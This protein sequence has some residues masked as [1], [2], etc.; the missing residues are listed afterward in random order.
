[1][2][3]AKKGGFAPLRKAPGWLGSN[4]TDWLSATYMREWSMKRTSSMCTS[5]WLTILLID[6]CQWVVWI[7][8]ADHSLLSVSCGVNGCLREWVRACMWP[9]PCSLWSLWWMWICSFTWVGS[10][11]EVPY[12]LNEMVEGYRGTWV[13]PVRGRGSFPSPHPLR[14]VDSSSGFTV[15][16]VGGSGQVEQSPL[17]LQA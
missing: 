12:K 17:T 16:R 9:I 7:K 6:R 1:M 4:L 15:D 8:E 14:P 3:G 11:L 2:F 10:Q 5:I 13:R